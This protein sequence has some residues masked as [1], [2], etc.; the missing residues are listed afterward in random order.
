MAVKSC[1]LSAH[2]LSNRSCAYSICREGSWRSWLYVRCVCIQHVWCT[3][4][5]FITGHVTAALKSHWDTLKMVADK[6]GERGSLQALWYY[7]GSY[8]SVT[9]I[10][11]QGFQACD[12][13]KVV[14]V[15]NPLWSGSGGNGG[16]FQGAVTQ[17][18]KG[19][20]RQ[21]AFWRTE[22]L[23]FLS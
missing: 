6:V 14:R 19:E 9:F 12:V 15:E 22:D 4:C 16:K 8:V 13:C 3:V 21:I 17:A 5:T 23:L 1:T 2:I 20:N 18:L 7:M 11:K 10:F